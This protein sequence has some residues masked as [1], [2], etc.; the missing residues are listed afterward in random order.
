MKIE[1]QIYT[2]LRNKYVTLKMDGIFNNEKHY[3]TMVYFTATQLFYGATIHL[4]NTDAE[5]I[6]NTI[7]PFFQKLKESGAIPIVSC[8]NNGRNIEKATR[9]NG[10]DNLQVLTNTNLL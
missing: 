3:L 10:I 7:A 6:A 2:E 4:E 5:S 9:S 8:T 1:T